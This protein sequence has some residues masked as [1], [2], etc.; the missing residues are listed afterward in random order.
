M[1][2][3]QNILDKAGVLDETNHDE[4]ASEEIF[5]ASRVL[6]RIEA[7]PADGQHQDLGQH[8]LDSS[9]AMKLPVF[10][11]DILKWTEFWEMYSASV[12]R[13]NRYAPVQKFVMLKSH[14]SGPALQCI[15]GLPVTD[16]CYQSAIDNLTE[17]FSK[18]ELVK[19]EIIRRLLNLPSVSE[20][21]SAMRTFV[22]HL[23]SHVR[24]LKAMGIT[25]DSLSSLLLPIAKG[26]LPESWRLQWARQRSATAGLDDF[27]AF[28]DSELNIR[29]EAAGPQGQHHGRRTPP[30]V[31]TVSALHMEVANCSSTWKCAACK[32]FKHGLG[33][34]FAYQSDC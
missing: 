12:H 27:I 33:K 25:S 26:K 10:D 21:H 34:C 1:R 24:T 6:S 18:P 4:L 13:N 2:A 17:R 32:K 22:D 7:T 3:I 15:K 31:P 8:H 11:G 5:K 23:V 14:L 19:E 16:A 29:E 30:A 28:L 20:D 9:V